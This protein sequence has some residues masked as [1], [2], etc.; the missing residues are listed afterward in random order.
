MKAHLRLQ[1]IGRDH[2]GF[3]YYAS[4]T[5][6]FVLLIADG[7]IFDPEKAPDLINSL[8]EFEAKFVNI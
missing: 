2:F 5:E 8:K 3:A 6:A 4:T 1:I 7:S